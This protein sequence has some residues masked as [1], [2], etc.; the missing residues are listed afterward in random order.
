MQKRWSNA[1]KFA[2][3]GKWAEKEADKVLKDQSE[4]F[5]DFAY[6]RL[7]DARAAQGAFKAMA[8]DFDLGFGHVGVQCFLEVKETKH[9]YRLSKDKLAQLPRLRKWYLTGKRFLVLVYHSE[10]DKWRIA[11]S[12]FFGWQG[13]PASWDLQPLELFDTAGAALFSTGWF[14]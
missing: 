5:A 10:I 13:V 11:P 7:P 12:E 14:R 3:R 1:N 4:R 2:D 6:E 8:A 9:E